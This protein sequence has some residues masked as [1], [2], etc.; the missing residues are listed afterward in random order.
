MTT[1]I[2]ASMDTSIDTPTES[3]VAAVMNEQPNVQSK[4]PLPSSAS[5]EACPRHTAS[6]PAAQGVRLRRW[7]L[8]VIGVLSVG[9]AALGALVPGLPTTIFVI[10]ASYCFTRSCPWL[11]QRL[12]R[13]RLFARSMSYVDGEREM[14]PR[15]R[16]TISCIIIGFSSVSAGILMATG[17]ATPLVLGIIAILAILGVVAVSLWKP[18]RRAGQLA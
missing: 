17:A 6:S 1:A 9:L 14:T 8:V 10:I 11:E 2:A 18:R 15:V 12:L 5:V 3:R 7:L 13:N 4:S 16:L